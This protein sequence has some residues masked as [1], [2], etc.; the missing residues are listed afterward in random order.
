MLS[1]ITAGWKYLTWDVTSLIT[2]IRKQKFYQWKKYHHNLHTTPQPSLSWHWKKYLENSRGFFLP[3][4][5]PKIRPSSLCSPG[6]QNQ[7][8]CNWHCIFKSEKALQGGREWIG[9]PMAYFLPKRPCCLGSLQSGDPPFPI[10][11]YIPVPEFP[12]EGVSSCPWASGSTFLCINP[13]ENP[14]KLLKTELIMRLK[15]QNR[16]VKKKDD[17]FLGK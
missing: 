13:C 12:P 11:A 14:L 7:F 3:P 6:E 1:K 17:I 8:H 15:T 16:R 5:T 2:E 10:E 9:L 4:N